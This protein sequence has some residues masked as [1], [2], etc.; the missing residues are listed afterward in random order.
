[1]IWNLFGFNHSGVHDTAPSEL[2]AIRIENLIIC[3][4]AV[5]ADPILLVRIDLTIE[6]DIDVILVISAHP[7]I[8]GYALRAIIGIYP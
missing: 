3:S 1:M 2:L 4:E 7:D 6:N 5:N 8:T